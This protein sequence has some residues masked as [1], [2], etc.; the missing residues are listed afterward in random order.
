MKVISIFFPLP[1]LQPC[2]AAALFIVNKLGN[3]IYST[4]AIAHMLSVMSL[5]YKKLNQLY[6]GLIPVNLPAA[7]YAER[8]RFINGCLCGIYF[9]EKKKINSGKFKE[10]IR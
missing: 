10:R 9:S 1:L 2:S 5:I 6:I 4:S 3:V 7:D 8:D